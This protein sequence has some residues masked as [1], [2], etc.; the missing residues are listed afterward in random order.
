LRN[1]VKKD[2]FVDLGWGRL[3]FASTFCSAEKL[4]K[5]ICKEKKGK[6]DITFYVENPHIIVSKAPQNIFLD[7]SH[8]YRINLKDFSTSPVTVGGFDVRRL[9]ENEI[10]DFNFVCKTRHMIAPRRE[11]IKKNLKSKKILYVVAVEK[12]S[13]K[14]IG[15][16]T[17]VDH[18]IAFN[19]SANGASLWCLAVDP[20]A[21]FPGIGKMLV[22][23]VLNYY[24]LKGRKYLDLSVMHD[25]KQAISLYK[26]M[27]FKRIPLFCLKHKNAFNEHLFIA[28]ESSEELNM[29]SQIIVDSARKR[30]ISCEVLDSKL[31]YFAL[32]FGGRRVV[33]KESLT[34]LT[35]AIAMSVCQNKNAAVSLLSKKGFPVP[36]QKIASGSYWD[37]HFLK[38]NKKIVVKAAEGEGGKGVYVDVGTVSEMSACIQKAKKLSDSVLLEE[39]VS[40]VDVRILVINF[41]AV[42]A[43]S[44]CPPKIIGTGNHTILQLIQKINRR[45]RAA[46]NGS[47]AIPVDDE[48]ERCLNKQGYCLR[49]VL[50]QNKTAVLRKTS[51]IH[52]GGLI[53]DVT[54]ELSLKFKTAAE[55]ISKQLDIPVV[56]IDFIVDKIDGEVYTFIEANERP[57]L[58]IHPNQ[59]VTENFLDLLFPQTKNKKQ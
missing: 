4:S 43:G 27:G 40:G 48:T 11:F 9:K 38:K 52:T 36:A 14:V 34:E 37:A 7:P 29:Y 51:N 54:S 13:K 2:F 5:V 23:Y 44:R 42:A 8:T 19:D 24:K 31:S 57:D 1:G 45:R 46:S 16:V 41:E 33:C 59:N 35:S 22:N 28:P 25:N 21:C 20:Q 55:E 32:S 58:T 30:G 12:K 56:G 47:I 17:C 6:R 53:E 18:K 15:C 10:S 39:Y 26:K 50:P 3:I 49:S